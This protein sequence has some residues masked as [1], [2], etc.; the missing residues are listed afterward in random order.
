M[1]DVDENVKCENRSDRE[2]DVEA[3]GG[4]SDE[5][6]KLSRCVFAAL[7]VIFGTGTT[8]VVAGD[9]NVDGSRG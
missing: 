2:M 1:I 4:A 8:A 6:I 9:G 7:I 5:V 3:G